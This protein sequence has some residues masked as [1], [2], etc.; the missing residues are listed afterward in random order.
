MQVHVS[1]TINHPSLHLTWPLTLSSLCWLPTLFGLHTSLSFKLSI[2][3]LNYLI[4]LSPLLLSQ[5]FALHSSF[6]LIL[7]FISTSSIVH[8]RTTNM[9]NCS[10]ER[11]QDFDSVEGTYA[12]PVHVNLYGFKKRYSSTS[13]HFS[14]STYSLLSVLYCSAAVYWAH[15]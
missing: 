8:P 13:A 9:T 10:T 6:L 4:V 12:C 15:V 5:L 1:L 14:C 11:I 2:H 7:V 3:S